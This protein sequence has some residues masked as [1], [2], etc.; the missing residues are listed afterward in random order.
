MWEDACKSVHVL[1]SV[2]LV[3]RRSV[4]TGEGLREELAH[5]R[6]AFQGCE[7]GACDL[8]SSVSKAP[9]SQY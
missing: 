3:G 8:T 2:L 1:V 7:R 5:D 4:I 6:I 9:R